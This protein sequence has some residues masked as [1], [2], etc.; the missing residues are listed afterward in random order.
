MRFRGNGR[1][2]AQQAC[3]DREI[4]ISF[5]SELA[6]LAPDQGG[7]HTRSLSPVSHGVID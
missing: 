5:H 2:V 1:K 4:V 6:P 3:A 7:R